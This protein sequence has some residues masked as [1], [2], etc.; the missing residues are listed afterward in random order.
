LQ[1]RRDP[2]ELQRVD[3]HIGKV[4]RGSARLIDGYAEGLLEKHEFEP[5]L[6]HLRARLHHLEQ[7]AEELRALA[8]DEEEIRVL[9]SR[10][11]VFAARVRDGLAQ[12][13][14]S[15][16]RE[17]IRALVKRVD[18]GQEQ[19]RVV[20]RVTPPT[21]PPSSAPGPPH[22]QHH[23]ARVLEAPLQCV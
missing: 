13:D 19:V 23:G 10:F 22:V 1:S 7:Q 15:T 8:Q 6:S 3:A 17:I 21:A 20:F 18:I 2:A 16:R 5:R 9:L 14:W 4:R 12:A 11:A